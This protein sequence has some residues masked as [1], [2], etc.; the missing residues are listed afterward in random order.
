MLKIKDFED[1]TIDETGN[2][3]S[4]RKNKYLK[5]T[6]NRNGYCKVTLQKDKYRKMFSVHRLVA[7]AYLKNYSNTLQVNH[8]NGIKT[9]NRVENLEMVTAKENM[10]KAVEIG[11]FDKCK[12][13]QRKN[14]IK[15]NLGKYH[16]LASESAKKRVAK[17]DKNN[18]LIQ[19]YNSISEASRKNNINITSI[20][21]SA[22]GKRKTGGGYIWH[23]V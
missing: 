6:I 1:Y 17:Y 14:A 2:V 3:F 10:Q 23:F 5:Q 21:Y 15:N 22:N 13:I 7:Q 20:S 4:I 19:V 11:L 9:D 16:I 8:I 12:E 18:N